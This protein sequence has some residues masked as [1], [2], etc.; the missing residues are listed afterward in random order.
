MAVAAMSIASANALQAD[1]VTLTRLAGTL[2]IGVHEIGRVVTDEP[3][4]TVSIASARSALAD[5]DL[6]CLGIALRCGKSSDG[7]N[8]HR[9]NA[10]RGELSDKI[11]SRA[12]R[13]GIHQSCIV[14]EQAGALELVDG[15][16]EQLVTCRQPK[17]A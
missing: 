10:G 5:I 17:L 4:T 8:H 12:L 16:I 13:T 2:A 9:R 11:A 1:T 6:A 7:W 3:C 14:C 15:Q